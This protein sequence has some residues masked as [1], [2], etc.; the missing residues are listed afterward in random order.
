MKREL[1]RQTMRADSVSFSRDTAIIKY[2]RSLRWWMREESCEIHLRLVIQHTILTF[3]YL[4]RKPE[5]FPGSNKVVPVKI[6][7]KH[8]IAQYVI[9]EKSQTDVMGKLT[10][11]HYQLIMFVASK[12]IIQFYEKSVESLI[13]EIILGSIFVREIIDVF[14]NQV[15]LT[16]RPITGQT[17]GN[18]IEIN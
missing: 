16:D 14:S 3:I 9:S 15:L 18:R 11:L 7:W 12:D 6:G 8:N 1:L 10:P 4:A 5:H 2:V 17:W 13:G